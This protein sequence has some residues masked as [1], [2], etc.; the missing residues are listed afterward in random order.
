MIMTS[1]SMAALAF[2]GD[3]AFG[4]GSHRPSEMFAHE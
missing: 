3:L 2:G 1:A 4:R